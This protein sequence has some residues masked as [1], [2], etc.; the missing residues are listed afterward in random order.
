[1]PTLVLM[2]L[3]IPPIGIDLLPRGDQDIV[4]HGHSNFPNSVEIFA[5]QDQ[6]VF[7]YSY[8]DSNFKLR[9]RLGPFV[10]LATSKI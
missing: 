8:N 4:L 1:M 9:V 10:G 7:I 2:I 3:S 5:T 6:D